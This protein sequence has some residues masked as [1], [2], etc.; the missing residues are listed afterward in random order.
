MSAHVWPVLISALTF[1]ATALLA[2]GALLYLHRESN[3][4]PQLRFYEQLHGGGNG[5][6]ADESLVDPESVRGRVLGVVG[7]VAS[8]GGFDR[9]IRGELERAGLPLRPVEYIALHLAAV[10][11]SGIVAQ[12]IVGSVA[13]TVVVVAVAA[14]APVA[15]LR[16]FARK[17]VAAFQAQLPDVLNL[18]SGSMRAG[19]G[20]L[21]SIG[22]VVQEMGSPAGP[23]FARVATEARLGLPVED[24]LERMAQR[25]QSEDFR[26]AVTAIAIQR[27]VEGTSRRSSTWSPRRSGTAR[28]CAGRSLRSRAR[29]V[30][31][32]SC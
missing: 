20:L 23:E 24:A 25:V 3:A 2:V 18:L 8:R 13:V 28:A 32:P 29:G 26:W 15:L 21:Q 9:A 6:A 4:L 11:A 16:Y 12:L 27:T 22:I 14:L 5:N 30:C 19:W 17:R 31:R 10:L 1:I 7:S